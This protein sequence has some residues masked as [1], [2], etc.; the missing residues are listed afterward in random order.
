MDFFKCLFL[1]Y[2]CDNLRLTTVEG[3]GSKSKG[4][5]EIQK[6]LAEG[7]GS[8]CGFCSAGMVMN[9]YSLLKRIKAFKSRNR[10]LL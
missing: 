7:N 6:R 2:S 4:Y 8:Q 5:H 10:G 3:L 9:M 1:L